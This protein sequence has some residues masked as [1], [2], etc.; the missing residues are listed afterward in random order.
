MLKLSTYYGL[1]ITRNPDSLENMKKAVW[2]T[3]FHYT[4]TDRKPR[5]STCSNSW[6]KYLKHKAEKPKERYMHPA[7]FDELTKGLLKKVYEEL[8]SEDLLKICLGGNTQNNNESFNSLVWNFASKHNF[9]GKKVL[10]IATLTAACIFNEGFL[11]VLKIMELMGVT[12]G[13]TARNYSDSVDNART[14]KA[15]KNAELNTKEPGIA[16]S[17]IS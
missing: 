7:T 3:F 17:S 8:S 10:E 5:H 6:C 14:L 2:V 15:N 1:S 9:T 12:I 11:P 4:S 13:Q 16:E